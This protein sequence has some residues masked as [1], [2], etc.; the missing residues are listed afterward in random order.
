[1]TSDF[2]PSIFVSNIR[3]N[4]DEIMLVKT[5]GAA[6]MGVDAHVI[7]IEVHSGAGQLGYTLVGLP[8]N[9][10]REGRERVMTALRNSGYRMPRGSLVVNLAPANLRK[11]GSAYD[12]G[13]ALGILA[14][15]NQV[16]DEKLKDYMILGELSLDGTLQQIRGALPIAILARQAGY[17]GLIVPRANAEE[18]AIVDRL[19]VIPVE[20][21]A[22]AAAFLGGEEEIEPVVRNTRQKFFDAA[23]FPDLD[24]AEVKG[25]EIPKRSL[26]I[27]AAGGHN[28]L[29]VGPPGAGK[30]MLAKR[31]PGILPPLSLGEALETT[32]V[33]SVAGMLP[34]DSSL[35]SLR[36]FRSPHH[37]A[38]DVAMVGGGSIP[39]PGEISLAHN[40]VLFLDEIPEFKRA[41][42]E[43]LRQPLEDRKILVSRARCA[44][45]FPANI[46]LVASMNPCPCGFY[47]DPNHD[48]ICSPGKIQRYMG[49]I[50]GPLMDRIDLQVEVTPLPFSDL[51]TVESSES[52]DEIRKRVIAARKIQTERF[53]E[54]PNVYCNAMMPSKLVRK[55]CRTSEEIDKLM[56]LAHQKFGFSARTFE[57]VLKLARTIADLE[58]VPELAKN[59]VL[60]AMHYRKL[61]R[62]NWWGT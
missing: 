54:Y 28:I 14:A 24:F 29:M 6:V 15:S 60:E 58:E 62:R 35:V 7:T 45:E 39:G 59:H 16:S 3:K 49:R 4:K 5:S 44:L 31:L 32:K 11:E 8:D 19:E 10:V 43:V 23:H 2:S 26:E 30:T 51:S 37:T 25:Q 55:F 21:L 52:S 18:A 48:C 20:T 12:L 1:L 57:R 40:G 33:H 22:R 47:T 61:D 34:A 17:K 56:N 42:L 9:A 53:E 27:A 50:S 46:M 38:S 41:V 36:P 13:I